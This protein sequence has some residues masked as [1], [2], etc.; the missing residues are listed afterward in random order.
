[1]SNNRTHGISV[2]NISRRNILTS[3]GGIAGVGVVGTN[4][5]SAKPKGNRE[6]VG[7]SYE[8]VSEEQQGTA[9]AQLNTHKN[10]AINGVLQLAGFT[11]PVGN[12]KPLKSYME[13]NGLRKYKIVSNSSEHKKDDLPLIVRFEIQND[14]LMAGV[15]T[16]PRSDYENLGF[17][18]AATDRPRKTPLRSESIKA[19]IASG[20]NPSQNPDVI[21]K[22]KGIPRIA[23]TPTDITIENTDST[24]DTQ[25]GDVSVQA[26]K[27]TGLISEASRD[28]KEKW[29]PAASCSDQRSM[30]THWTYNTAF[31]GQDTYDHDYDEIESG[32]WAIW[33]FHSHFSDKPE[34]MLC[35]YSGTMDEPAPT[36]VEYEITLGDG[37]SQQHIDFLSPSPDNDPNDAGGKDDGVL[38]LILDFAAAAGGP[39]AA[40]GKAVI[41]FLLGSNSD[42]VYQN[43]ESWTNSN[44]VPKVKMVWDMDMDG[45]EREDIPGA[46]DKGAGVQFRIDNGHSSGRYATID[47]KSRFTFTHMRFPSN[48]CRCTTAYRYTVTTTYTY[49]TGGYNS[50]PPQ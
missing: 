11:I 38:G 21:V 34:S 23:N 4:F 10:G 42:P 35:D 32:Q 15:A 28:G 41:D 14:E 29:T 16:R 3:V 2:D 27:S 5:A 13:E 17:A 44:G 31:V 33:W 48:S 9:S 18:L 6:F 20:L 43:K 7:V 49:N 39:Y 19:E 37:E 47:G 45:S 46:P 12:E 30:A 50:I 8:A 26:T 25:S 40:A 36:S 24:L 22:D 1:M